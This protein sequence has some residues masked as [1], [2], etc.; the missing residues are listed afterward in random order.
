MALLT[1]TQGTPHRVWSLLQFLDASDGQ[2]SREE[3]GQWMN[4]E[5][6]VEGKPTQSDQSAVNQTIEAAAGLGMS[7]P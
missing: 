7:P 3:V 4:P 6:Y 1:A 2:L 5:V